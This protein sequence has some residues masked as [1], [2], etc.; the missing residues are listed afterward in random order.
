VLWLGIWTVNPPSRRIQWCCTD[1]SCLFPRLQTWTTTQRGRA[2]PRQLRATQQYIATVSS[3]T[4]LRAK[5]LPE[6][7]SK[8]RKLTAG[9]E[10]LS[11]GTEHIRGEGRRAVELALGLL[12][13]AAELPLVFAF[14]VKDSSGS[15]S[16]RVSRSQVSVQDAATYIKG[17][18]QCPPLG[19]RAPR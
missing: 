15:S 16:I 18:L 10:A 19:Q 7:P 4:P 12:A 1:A 11:L 14:A 3:P 17:P 5:P 9:A 2:A 6:L 8:P 13:L